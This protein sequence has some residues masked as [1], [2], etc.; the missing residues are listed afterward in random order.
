MIARLLMVLVLLLSTAGVLVA[1][2]PHIGYTYP[3]GGQP[4]TSFDV[5]LGGQ[6]LSDTANVSVSGSGVTAEVADYA[7]RYELRELRGLYRRKENLEAT[8]KELKEKGE[9]FE[10]QQRQL[11]VVMDKLAVAELPDGIEAANKQQ[12]LRSY[13]G[14][15]KE[16]FN[17][18]IAERLSLRISIDP[19]AEPGERE[20]RVDTS[21]GLSNPVFFEIGVLA[22][23]HETEPNDDHMAP[24][25]QTIPVP[26]VI[27]G[28]IRPGDIDH[29]RFEARKGERLVINVSAR[30]IIP[31][32]ADAVPGWFQAVAAL[33]DEDGNEVAY[34]DDYRFNPDPVL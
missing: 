11:N 34:D 16:Q 25:L 17:P 21:E 12:A 22:E 24:E 18:Q 33:Y 19:D 27:N 7:V 20:L 9:P 29:F 32:L 30:R 13:R 23:I 26:S 15:N 28:Q 1:E 5:I 14:E 31:Y 3:A 4:G 10:K 2:S 6:Y 8:I